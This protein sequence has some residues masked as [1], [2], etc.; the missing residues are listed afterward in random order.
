MQTESQDGPSY[1]KAMKL[2][3]EDWQ[4]DEIAKI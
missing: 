1:L 3:I 4:I 2:S